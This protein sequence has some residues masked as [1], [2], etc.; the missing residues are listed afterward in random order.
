MKK[1]TGEKKH[2]KSKDTNID[3]SEEELSKIK[4]ISEYLFTDQYQDSA[5]YPRFEE[6]FGAFCLEKSIDLP[7]VFKE[8][9]KVHFYCLQLL[10]INF[11]FYLITFTP[12]F[13]WI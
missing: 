13:R 3:L 5:A 7:K 11:Y 8:R 10:S 4:T 12:T 2:S 9:K 1:K 6:C